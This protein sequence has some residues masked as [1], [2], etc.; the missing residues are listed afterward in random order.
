MKGTLDN[1]LLQALIALCRSADFTL[2]KLR[3]LLAQAQK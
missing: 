3:A 1:E 2:E